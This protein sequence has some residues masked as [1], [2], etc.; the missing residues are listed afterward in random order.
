MGITETQET[1]GRGAGTG[2]FAAGTEPLPEA[3]PQAIETGSSA[4]RP[5]AAKTEPVTEN[6]TGTPSLPS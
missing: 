6:V 2:G 3:L 4:E 5:L 1:E